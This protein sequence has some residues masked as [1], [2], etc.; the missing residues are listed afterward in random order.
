[1][2]HLYHPDYFNPEES[3]S[4]EEEMHKVRVRPR[5]PKKRAAKKQPEHPK[6][7]TKRRKAP[8]PGARHQLPNPLGKDAP[9]KPP[10]FC[11]P[12][13]PRGFKKPMANPPKEPSVQNVAVMKPTFPKIAGPKVPG[14]RKIA[15]PRYN[16]ISSG[17]AKKE[18]ASKDQASSKDPNATKAQGKGRKGC[19]LQPPPPK[20]KKPFRPKTIMFAPLKVRSFHVDYRYENER[21]LSSLFVTIVTPHSLLGGVRSM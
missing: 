21:S 8:K 18:G 12:A 14:P 5:Q 20:P 9:A 4:D 7:S 2:P 10:G 13:P 11:K 17:G 15:G 1:M 3:A 6:P 19:L 16:L